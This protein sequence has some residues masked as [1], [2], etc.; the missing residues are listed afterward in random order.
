MHFWS[1][2]A[3][4]RSGAAAIA[5]LATTSAHAQVKAFDIPAEDAVKAIPE[6]AR[7]AGIEIFVPANQLKGVRT[8]AIKGSIELHAALNRLLAGTG[9]SI[10]SD[11]GQTIAL[12]APPK[13]AEAASDNGAAQG[14]PTETVVV[15]G[16]NIRGVKETTQ[17]ISTITSE[18]IRNSGYTRIE[19]VLNTIPQNFADI[20]FQS[21]FGTGTSRVASL[22]AFNPISAVDLRGLGPESTLTL[23]NGTRSAGG[24]EGRAVDI[25]AIPVAAVDRVDIVTGGDSAIYGSDAVGGVVNFITKHSFDGL[26]FDATYGGTA[27]GGQR[28]DASVV[29][30][31]QFDA[32]GF[33]VAASYGHD[34]PF[35]LVDV[36]LV[37]SPTP[38]GSVFRTLQA[39]TGNDQGSAYVGAEYQLT[40]KIHLFADGLYFKRSS[41][42]FSAQ[43]FA[44]ATN[45]SPDTNVYDAEEYRGT[46]GATI[47]LS[48]IWSLKVEGTY[49]ADNFFSSTNFTEDFGIFAF[50]LDSSQ[51]G[52]SGVSSASAVL[53]GELP[54][55]FGITAKTAIGAELQRETYHDGFA[56]LLDGFPLPTQ[57]VTNSNRTIASAFAELNIPI[58]QDESDNRDK[59]NVSLAG[60][61][62][63]YSDFGS[64][65]NPQVGVFWR[66]ISSLKLRGNYSSAFRAPA[67]V[68]F[69]NTRTVNIDDVVDPESASGVSPLLTLSGNRSTLRP[70]TAR[71]WSGGAD[72]D[73]GFLPSTRLSVDYYNIN[74]KNRIETPADGADNLLALERERAYASLINRNPSAAQLSQ[75][76]ASS[77]SGVIGNSTGIPFDPSTQS[78]EAVFPGIVV[79]DNRLNNIAVERAEGIDITLSTL[80]ETSIG[81]FGLNSTLTYSLSHTFNVTATSP[82]LSKEDE[83]GQPA[84][85]RLRANLSWSNGPYTLNGNV[86]Y[87]G[88]YDDTLTTPVSSV[89][90]WTTLDLVGRIDLSKISSDSVLAGA[91]ITLSLLNAFDAGSPLALGNTSGLLY[92]PTNANPFGRFISISVRKKF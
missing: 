28:T 65:F 13:N 52:L 89:S 77:S 64:T 82:S 3:V 34:E 67:L 80:R 35:D 76:I 12:S 71:I 5:L 43:L 8:P 1:K 62:D 4:L 20:N 90:S 68:E 39:Q 37:A 42:Q 36:G 59:L 75:I 22:N 6:F 92:D 16:T 73:L 86:N 63:H 66:P 2:K 10:V 50:T 70:E 61:Y 27:N 79:F 87:T 85:V 44:E 14:A 29:G 81:T 53:D 45:E 91:D 31:M 15:T 88:G 49:S 60:R 56:A 48:S 19:S 72:Y 83:V 17:P 25:S 51:K 38:G 69:S 18:D 11:D 54:S 24:I 46:I 26:Q 58:L 47:D 41:T 55:I 33:V 7:Q 9:I 30:G 40:D 57:P 21:T 23:I 74:Y 32:G 78:A 84:A